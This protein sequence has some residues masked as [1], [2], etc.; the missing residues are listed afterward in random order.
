MIYWG[1]DSPWSVCCHTIGGHTHVVQILKSGYECQFSPTIW[2]AV[3]NEHI[4]AKCNLWFI[5][6]LANGHIILQILS[7][8]TQLFNQFSFKMYTT[9]KMSRPAF[10][11]GF[12]VVNITLH[13][14]VT[15]N[16]S[17]DRCR[18]TPESSS[19][20][21]FRLENR[22]ETLPQVLEMSKGGELDS[23]QKTAKW[24]PQSKLSSLNI[25]PSFYDI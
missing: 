1:Y 7:Y 15:M 6:F 24:Q 16:R 2:R 20:C 14:K 5:S 23:S 13:P 3:I 4:M 10:W 8:K 11:F 25:H 22:S 18:Q 21:L 12:I 19:K 9:V 17:F